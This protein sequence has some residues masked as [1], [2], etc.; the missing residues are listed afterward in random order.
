MSAHFQHRDLRRHAP[1][2]RQ[3]ALGGRALLPPH[4]QVHA[5]AADGDRDPL[6]AGAVAPFQDTAVDALPPNWLVLHIPPNEGISLQ[7]EV[8]RLGRWWTSPP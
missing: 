7:F 5:A 4:R 2:D 1:R 3:L 8:K 6:Q